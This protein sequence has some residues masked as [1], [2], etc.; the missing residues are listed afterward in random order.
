M[1]K[2][3]YYSD[4]TEA[5]KAELTDGQTEVFKLKDKGEDNSWDDIAMIR[6]SSTSSV[7]AIYFNGKKKIKQME[8]GALAAPDESTE[9]KKL[10]ITEMADVCDDKAGLILQLMTRESI[11]S[12]TLSQKAQAFGVLIEKGRLLRGEATQIITVD[13]RRNLKDLIPAFLKE[14]KRRGITIDGEF[15]EVG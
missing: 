6:Q 8:A 11:S 2:Q 15:A 3:Y 12:A 4:L 5:Q 7:K 14:A 1:A 9:I 10:S 13:D